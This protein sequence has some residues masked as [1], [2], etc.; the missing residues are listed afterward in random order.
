MALIDMQL[1]QLPCAQNWFKL[2][3]ACSGALWAQIWREHGDRLLH[4]C[5][6]A[7]RD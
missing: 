2:S 3:A 6:D 7:A 5:H 4:C 1:L